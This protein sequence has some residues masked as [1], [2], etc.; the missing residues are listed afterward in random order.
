MAGIL[1]NEVLCEG[2]RLRASYTNEQNKC[3][4]SRLCYQNWDVLLSPKYCP[5]S[6]VGIAM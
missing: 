6:D 3:F 2:V 4:R 5:G 1:T